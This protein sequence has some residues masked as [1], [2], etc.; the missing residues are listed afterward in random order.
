MYLVI[1]GL[2][3][4]LLKVAQLGPVAD[5]PWWVVLMPLGAAVAWWAW[6]DS[7]GWTQRRQ[8]ERMDERKAERR[9]KHLENLGMDE[10][11]RRKRS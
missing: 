7:T 3:L 8:M 1:F 5:W 6:A 11:G 2:L 4:L 9:R 10:R